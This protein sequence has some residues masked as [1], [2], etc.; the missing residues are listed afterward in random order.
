LSLFTL[1][2]DKTFSKRGFTWSGK[3]LSSAL[4]TLT[5]TYPIENKFVNPEQ[6]NDEDFQRNHHLHWGK[7]FEPGEVKITWH[8]PSTEEI[9]FALQLF[10]ELVEP[11]MNR[12]DLLLETSSR[13]AIWRNDFCRHLSFVR[14]AFT[15]IPTIFKEIISPDIAQSMLTTSDII[16]EIP[17]MIASVESLASGF[18]LTDPQDAR[19]KYIAGLRRR[20]GE[21]LHAVSVSLQKQGEENTVDAVQMLIS[22]IRTYMLE[23]GDSKDRY[24][25]NCEQ[26]NSEIN[27]A[28]QYS[29]QKV[30]PRAGFVR[31]A[32][33]YHS[34]RLYWNS[35]E[36]ARG[37]LENSLLDDVVEWSMWHYPSV[38][39]S[40]QSLLESLTSVLALMMIA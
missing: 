3:L 34:S 31:R 18:C 15:G 28:R 32:R 36:R 20:F 6:W 8:V 33:F 29:G 25:V 2:R 23:Y 27:V 7:L 38:R 9:D 17:E 22:S 35:I 12:L 10:R 26:Y 11:A 4:I 40:S 5:H 37:P 24:Y 21:F 1:L 13:D 39:Q 30:W 16:N 19:Y 14:E